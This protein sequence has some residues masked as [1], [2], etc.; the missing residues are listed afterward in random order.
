MK[1]GMNNVVTT[2]Y[3]TTNDPSFRF[4][5]EILTAMLRNV[6]KK[7]EHVD[8]SNNFFSNQNSVE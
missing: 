3:K 1:N 5:L 7:K 8:K 4:D 2:K 6:C